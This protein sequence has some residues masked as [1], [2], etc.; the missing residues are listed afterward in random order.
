[1]KQ[2]KCPSKKLFRSA[3]HILA[4]VEFINRSSGS[5]ETALYRLKILVKNTANL[6]YTPMELLLW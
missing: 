2:N 3:Q 6:S 4:V 5:S 1:M